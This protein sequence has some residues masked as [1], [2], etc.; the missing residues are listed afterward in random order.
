M[1]SKS[2]LVS[3][4]IGALYAL[5]LVTYIVQSLQQS[6]GASQ[7]GVGIGTAILTPHIILVVLADIF[8]AVA[9]FTNKQGFALTGWILFSVGAALFIPYA[10]FLIVSIVCS[11]IGYSKLK[12]VAIN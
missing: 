1:K 2:L 7:I 5:C 3:L 4:I 6:T 10:P 8:N 12:K 11:F 9:L